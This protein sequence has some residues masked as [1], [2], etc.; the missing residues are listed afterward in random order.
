MAGGSVGLTRGTFTVNAAVA[1]NVADVALV[2]QGWATI[3]TTGAALAADHGIIEITAD[4]CQVKYLAIDG[5]GATVASGCCLHVDNCDRTQLVALLLERAKEHNIIVDGGAAWTM[6]ARCICR[7]SYEDSVVIAASAE[8]TLKGCL[9]GAVDS[10]VRTTEDGLVLSNAQQTTVSGCLMDI[11]RYPL[12]IYDSSNCKIQVNT[13]ELG[14][15]HGLAIG[16]NSAGNIVIGNV[17]RDNSK[18]TTATYDG[19]YLSGTASRNLIKG[20]PIFND[21]D[22]DGTHGANKQRY[23]VNVSASGCVGNQ[24][25]NNEFNH[26]SGNATAPVSD[27]GTKT[28]FYGN[29]GYIAKGEIRS[30]GASLTAGAVNTVAFYWN[31]PEKQ[32]ILV[33]KVTTDVTTASTDTGACIDIGIADSSSGTNLGTEFFDDLPTDATGINCANAMQ[34][35]EDSTNATDAY[36]VGLYVTEDSTKL[37]GTYSIEYQGR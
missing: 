35:C 23:G 11:A 4:E 5:N 13:I 1:M 8:T 28:Y 27:S 32:D 30:K 17:I 34:L 3:L 18:Q 31:N 26:E 22:Y 9:I 7:E 25:I 12:Y 19:V 36:V 2:G 10:S 15:Q 29:D 20:N 14:R 21:T 37:V 6:I 16:G 24:V 33:R